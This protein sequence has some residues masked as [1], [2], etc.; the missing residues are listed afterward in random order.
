MNFTLRWS[1]TALADLERLH[2]FLLQRA[3]VAEDLEV[4]ERALE[5]I[6]AAGDD[7]L[8][9]TPFSFRK[10]A[11]GPLWRE[12]IIPFG[13]TGYVALYEIRPARQLVIV[14]AV[15]DQ[16]EEDYH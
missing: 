13:S 7:L 1:E 3:S 4:A 15:R 12:L 8:A 6:K 14:H 5:A 10:V 9:R 16:R 2:D 11:R